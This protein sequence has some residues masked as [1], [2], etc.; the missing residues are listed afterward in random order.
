MFNVYWLYEDP[1]HDA[2]AVK[3]QM[4][5]AENGAPGSMERISRA[6]C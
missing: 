3:C 2:K 1:E 6:Y 4:P 5:L